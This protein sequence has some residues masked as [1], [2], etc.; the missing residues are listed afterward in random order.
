MI[1]GPEHVGRQFS[2][3]PHGQTFRLLEVRATEVLA[4][5]D[6]EYVAV[7]MGRFDRDFT[8]IEPTKPVDHRALLAKYIRLVRAHEGVDFLDGG[9]RR[10]LAEE[11]EDSVDRDDPSTALELSFTDA[12][13]AELQRLAGEAR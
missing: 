9:K 10:R 12:E 3:G 4:F 8:L 11:G 7:P 6:G 2:Y 1:P 13:W 5:S